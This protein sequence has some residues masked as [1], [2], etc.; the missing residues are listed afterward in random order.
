MIDAEAEAEAEGHRTVKRWA[1][2]EMQLRVPAM[3]YQ[4]RHRGIWA[5]GAHQRQQENL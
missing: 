1:M 5:R 3:F 4:Q 2:L